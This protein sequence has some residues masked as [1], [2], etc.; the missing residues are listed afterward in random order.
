MSPAA[1]E[2]KAAPKAPVTVSRYPLSAR[3][4]HWTLATCFVFLGLTGLA[5]FHP[6]L[7]WL[8]SF[9]GGGPLVRWLHPAVGVVLMIAWIPMFLRFWRANMP[10]RGDGAWLKGAKEVLSG[11]EESLPEVGKYNAGQ[12]LVF[13]SFS[14]LV[15]ALFITGILTWDQ[16]FYGWT[17]IPQKRLAVLGHAL[18]AIG[19]I[20][21]WVVHAYAA[22]WVRGTI[23]AMTRGYVTGGWAWRHHRKWLRDLFAGRRK[24]PTPTALAE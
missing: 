23:Q 10:E 20:T 3:I 14:I 12:K 18:F 2:S 8:T 11:H 9:F 17:T 1:V 21:V 4:N 22:V 7:Y 6:S 24:G 19:M 5:L 15:P 13:W 16:Y